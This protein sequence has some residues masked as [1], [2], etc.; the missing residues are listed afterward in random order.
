[1]NVT[2]MRQF[3]FRVKKTGKYLIFLIHEVVILVN[4]EIMQIHC[5][6]I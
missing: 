6:C 1:M 5:R 2:A 4:T 3:S